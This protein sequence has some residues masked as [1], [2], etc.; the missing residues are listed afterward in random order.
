MRLINTHTFEQKDRF[1]D[2]RTPPYAIL[3][4]R[5]G[6]HEVSFQDFHNASKATFDNPSAH[7]GADKNSGAYKIAHACAQA[8]KAGLEWLWIDTCCIDKSSSAELGKAI[9]SMFKWYQ[10]AQ[11]CFAHLADVNVQSKTNQKTEVEKEVLNSEWF[12]RGWT[13]QEVLAPR[14]MQFFDANWGLIGSRSQLTSII[15]QAAR[16]SPEH[17]KDFRHATIAQKMSWMADRVTSE[18]DTAYCMLGIFDLNMDLRYGEGKKAFGRLQEMIISSSTDESIFAWRCDRFE[19]SGLLAPWPDCFRQSGSIILRPDKISHAR[20]AYQMTSQ[21]LRFPA[22]V[23]LVKD[24]EYKG[25][26]YL[27]KGKGK[28]VDL[29]IQCWTMEQGEL[30][31]AVLFLSKSGG[32]WKRVRCGELGSAKKV[33]MKSWVQFGAPALTLDITIP[34]REVVINK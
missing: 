30:R 3:S 16:I 7:L 1:Q 23:M 4:H 18:E 31:A 10:E 13:L 14:E 17:L 26:E 9:N 28:D 21:G 24:I 34:Q 19:S 5:W 22:P 8:K 32:Y 12:R 29:T 25:P 11:V 6:E 33:K 20:P 2:N 27:L 15:S